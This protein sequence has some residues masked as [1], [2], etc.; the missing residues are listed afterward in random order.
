MGTFE[1][2]AQHLT[3]PWVDPSLLPKKQ[4]THDAVSERATVAFQPKGLFQTQGFKPIPKGIGDDRLC[5]FDGTA[6]I[7]IQFEDH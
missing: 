3:V 2:H 4:T 5:R 6:W 7:P 1:D